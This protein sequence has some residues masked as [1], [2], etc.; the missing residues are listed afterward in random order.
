MM[1]RAVNAQRMKMIVSLFVMVRGVAIA[2]PGAISFPPLREIFLQWQTKS[3]PNASITCDT[4]F[5]AD[6]V[7]AQVYNDAK[8]SLNKE[9]I[10]IPHLNARDT[11]L[12]SP[13]YLAADEKKFLLDELDRIRDQKWPGDLFPR[14]KL[15]RQEEVIATV[16]IISRSLQPLEGKL[17]KKIHSF[18][19]P[20][21]F[22]QGELCLL[23]LQED[24]VLLTTGEWLIYKKRNGVWIRFGPLFRWLE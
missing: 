20:I 5:Y 4:F 15:I 22:R 2:Q 1:I 23:Y 7:N 18:T 11:V 24:D 17:C 16:G 13:L 19:A 10:T 6:A 12:E 3:F 14:S 9:K 21:F 8:A